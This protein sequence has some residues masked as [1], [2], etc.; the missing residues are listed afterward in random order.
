MILI[1][2]IIKTILKLFWQN[3][4]GNVKET[5]KYK[6]EKKIKSSLKN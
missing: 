1:Q 3:K 5:E 2:K 6:L 4:K